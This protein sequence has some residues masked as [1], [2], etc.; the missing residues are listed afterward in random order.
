MTT[1]AIYVAAAIAEII[2]CYALWAVARLG[3]PKP[4]LLLG[5]AS[6]IAFG[7]LL[8]LVD[9]AAAGRAYAIYGG[10]Y[11]AMSL[12]FL[13]SVESEIPDRWDLIGAAVCVVGALI[14]L[15]GPRAT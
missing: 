11:I 10:I 12:L 7:G 9:V 3:A 15:Y 13:W 5:V 1:I 6:L 14:I 2:G 4:W 8:T